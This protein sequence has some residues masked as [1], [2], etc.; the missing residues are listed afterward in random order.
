MGS[1]VFRNVEMRTELRNPVIKMKFTLLRRGMSR[2]LVTFGETSLKEHH[3]ISHDFLAKKM[4]GIV[5]IS[6]HLMNYNL[7]D[8][9]N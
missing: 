6:F 5:Q 9:F 7:K 8:E 1:C 2:N 3:T 4:G